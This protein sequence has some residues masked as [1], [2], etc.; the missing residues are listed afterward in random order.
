L[1]RKVLKANGSPEPLFE[2][3]D[4]RTYFTAV[5][6]IHPEAKIKAQVSEQVS[7]QVVNILKFC[8]TPKKR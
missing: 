6:H 2:T 1:I 8:T 7:E 5:L 4:E 3:D